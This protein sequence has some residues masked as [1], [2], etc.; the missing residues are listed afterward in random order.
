MSVH[1]SRGIRFDVKRRREIARLASSS[2]LPARTVPCRL[3]MARA[4]PRV[5]SAWAAKERAVSGA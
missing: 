3:G 5:D 1:D 2:P 4:L